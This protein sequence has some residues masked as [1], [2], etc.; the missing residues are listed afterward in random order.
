M[1]HVLFPIK[2]DGGLLDGPQ[3][4]SGYF[5][6]GGKGLKKGFLKKTEFLKRDK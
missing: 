2:W 6:E 3:N 5:G 1:K 4:S